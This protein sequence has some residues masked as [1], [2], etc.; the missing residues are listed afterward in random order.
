MI[1]LRRLAVFKAVF[2]HGSITGAAS[3]LGYSPSAVSQ[4]ITTLERETKLE[5]F[6]KSGR[7]IRPTHAGEVLAAQAEIVLDQ[8]RQTEEALA[9][10]RTGRAGRM[11]VAAFA[12][13]GGSMVPHALADFTRRHPGVKC[14]LVIAE[15]DEALTRLTTG[16]SEVAV[17]AVEAPVVEDEKT[18][19]YHSLLEDPY[20]VVLPSTHP[21]AGK[22]VLDLAA[23]S[24]EAWIA[25]AS[26]RCNCLPTITEACAR[27][28]FSPRFAIEAD[29]F[30]TALGF[31][32]A[33]IGV[34]IVPTLALGS[35]PV[36]VSI[37]TIAGRI[38]PKRYV[39]AVTRTADLQHPV[40]A[41]ML[42]A[43][44]SSAGSILRAVA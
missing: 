36:G 4:N 22:T 34:A 6:Q 20:R 25:T 29:E 32:A 24:D 27:A 9:A 21:L 44:D 8:M 28:G 7:G 10:V 23:L 2:D 40:V 12:T 15:T 35:L 30:A 17:I 26:A 43:M 41:S 13:A 37:H 1:D 19:S 14:E 33:G 11:R 16:Q 39:Y 31:V 38:E 18:I 42:T 3:A 5:L